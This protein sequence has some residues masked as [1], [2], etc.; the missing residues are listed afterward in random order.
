MRYSEDLA[1]QG[2][3]DLT[4]CDVTRRQRPMRALVSF[5][6]KVAHQ[7]AHNATFGPFAA[8]SLFKG[9]LPVVYPVDQHS[10]R[11]IG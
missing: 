5:T 9:D 7:H 10:V 1:I 4:Q 2:V 6:D 8:A 3:S 11:G